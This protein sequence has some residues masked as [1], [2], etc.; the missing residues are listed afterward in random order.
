MLLHVTVCHW[1]GTDS[2]AYRKPDCHSFK[3][4]YVH[5]GSQCHINGIAH[6]ERVCDV[7]SHA[8][9]NATS[10]SDTAGF[11]DQFANSIAISLDRHR[12]AGIDAD[13]YPDSNRNH[14]TYTGEC[15][16]AVTC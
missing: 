3:H 11:A 12:D 2:H 8:D 14:A 13:I 6:H 7:N 15:A 16:D 4:R 5:S 10:F 1:A 9:G